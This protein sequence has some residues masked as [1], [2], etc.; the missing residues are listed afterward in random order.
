M[1]LEIFTNTSRYNMVTIATLMASLEIW[2]FPQNTIRPQ[3]ILTLILIITI[4]IDI[5]NILG[6]LAGGNHYITPLHIITFFIIILK[7]MG[8]NNFL[9]NVRGSLKTRKYL[10]RRLRLFL[11]PLIK[12]RRMMRE[13]RARIMATSIIQVLISLSYHHHH[14][15]HHH[16]IIIIII[17]LLLLLG[18]INGWILDTIYTSSNS[19]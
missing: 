12:P 3:I 2:Y 10:M 16:L 9:F 11:V 4:F 6:Q 5:F 8:L 13:I 19:I 7:L 1:S 15:Y 14:H 17:L 18:N